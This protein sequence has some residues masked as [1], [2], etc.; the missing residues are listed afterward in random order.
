MANVRR[1]INKFVNEIVVL[2]PAKMTD[3]IKI[4]WLPIPV[5]LVFEENGV[6]NVHPAVVNVLFEHLVK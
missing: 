6:I 3:T 2:T 1:V 5:Y 4:S